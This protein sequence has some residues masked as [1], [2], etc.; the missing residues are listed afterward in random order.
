MTRLVRG[1]KAAYGQDVGILMMDNTFARLPGDIGNAMTFEFPVQF[2][3]IDGSTNERIVWQRD[4]ALL[5]PYVGAAQELERS[6]VRAITT[7]CGFLAMFQP[8]LAASVHVPL[9]TSSLL[10][11]PLVKRMIRP[12]QRV[13]IITADSSALDETHFNACGWSA[14]EIPVA[15]EG[16]QARSA[17]WDA[18]PKNALEYDVDAVAADMR[19]AAVALLREHPEVGAIVLECTNMA[20]YAHVVQEATGLPVFDVQTLTNLVY[21]ATHRV[22]YGDGR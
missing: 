15:L 1:G 22:P 19:D 16:M 4:R 17:F 12:D 5:A 20:P 7:S 14:T 10:L 21:E 18:Y 2:R 11:V 8:E 13:G 6:G 9:F 3:V